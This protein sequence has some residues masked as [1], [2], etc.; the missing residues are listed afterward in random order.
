MELYQRHRM[1][2]VILRLHPRE[3]LPP[4]EN[5][6]RDYSKDRKGLQQYC[7]A[8]GKESLLIPSFYH[9]PSFY[10]SIN[11]ALPTRSGAI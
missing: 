3:T 8:R 9:F 4:Q 7:P 1:I 5:L 10:L 6:Y 2:P 11:A